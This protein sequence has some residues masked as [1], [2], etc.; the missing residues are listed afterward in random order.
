MLVKGLQQSLR[1]NRPLE[2]MVDP[3]ALARLEIT[4]D[5]QDIE[6]LGIRSFG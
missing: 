1:T 4:H 5:A 6:S 3:L 2:V